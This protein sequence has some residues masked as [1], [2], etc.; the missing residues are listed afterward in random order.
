[1]AGMM[2]VFDD[3]VQLAAWQHEARD[4]HTGE[5]IGLTVNS[6][7]GTPGS[8][9]HITRTEEG[10]IPLAA[11]ADLKG[12]EGEQ[13]GEHTTMTPERFEALKAD[14]AAN[15]IRNPIFITVDPGMPPEISEGSNRRDAAAALGMTHVPALVR[16]FGHSE[17][18][19]TVTERAF[20]TTWYHGVPTGRQARQIA[21]SGLKSGLSTKRPYYT[22]A[23]HPD[24]AGMWAGKHG[25]VVEFR[26]PKS[27]QADYLTSPPGE[28]GALGPARISG[29]KRFIPA[30][31]VHKVTYMDPHHTTM[32]ADTI[33]GQIQLASWQTEPRDAT[34]RWSLE[35]IG[36]LAS[37]DYEGNT[38][39]RWARW[40]LRNPANKIPADQ[41]ARWNAL[42]ED[43][44]RRGVQEPVEVDSLE[45]PTELREGHHRYAAAL[46][47]G[48]KDI[49]VIAST[50][51]ATCPN[52]SC[53]I[54]LA[55]GWH[56][57]WRHELRG[58]HGEWVG[59]MAATGH[60]TTGKAG[61]IKKIDAAWGRSHGWASPSLHRASE[62]LKADDWKTAV[63]KLYEA[64]HM[65]DSQMKNPGT[66]SRAGASYRRLA[67]Q[68]EEEYTHK[69]ALSQV[70]T[71]ANT[72]PADQVAGWLG[73]GQEKWDRDARVFDW[74]SE[75]DVAGRM[76]WAGEFGMSN[77]TAEKLQELV[78]PAQQVITPDAEHAVSLHE[79]IHGVETPLDTPF[80][81]SGLGERDT[82]I[83]GTMDRLSLA[84]SSSDLRNAR[85]ALPRLN[86]YLLPGE[87][88]ITEPEMDGLVK[89]GYLTRITN[90]EGKP[91]WGLTSKW[92]ADRIGIDQ[93]DEKLHMQAY[94]RYP[95]SR[96]E[97]GFT[98]LG[99]NHHMPDWLESVGAAGKLTPSLSEEGAADV[100]ARFNT[101]AMYDNQD[102]IRQIYKDEGTKPGTKG[103]G[104]TYSAL[105]NAE[106]ALF[107]PDRD[108]VALVEALDQAH[109]LSPYP[110]ITKRIEAVMSKMNV[111]PGT[112]K[113]QTMGEYAEKLRDLP[114]NIMNNTAW[115]H[116]PW[117]TNAALRWV[118]TI[119]RA[120]GYDPSYPRG[121]GAKRA[122]ELADEIN[123]QGPA[124]KIPVMVG[125]FMRAMKADDVPAPPGFG[126]SLRQT[127]EGTLE[128]SWPT[129]YDQD[130]GAPY[131]RLMEELEWRKGGGTV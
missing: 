65:A 58:P 72:R 77:V 33:T 22:L 101:Q 51:L 130:A 108:P 91:A 20:T 42:A 34:G 6:Y 44:G 118:Q 55:G 110:D 61:F 119:A 66:K 67:D 17:E 19:G 121:P 109:S 4:P 115:G 62:A 90:Y 13:P 39:D 126:R 114:V 68:I 106:H 99:T 94:Q 48:Q 23:S 127:L 30:E 75:P 89:R 15:G 105:A 86:V 82:Q 107:S 47:H 45:H 124:G 56:D 93:D 28:L 5:W 26:I 95:V 81:R 80:K 125:Q 87:A 25:A 102:E 64:A 32:A 27:K 112:L 53:P 40:F 70:V 69:D 97:E 60:A 7:Q 74:A 111:P 129:S 103:S 31:W 43:V 41:L 76:G 9:R 85:F 92:Y 29:I 46:L 71:M 21:R 8:L 123:Q 117:E 57:A 38:V 84:G 37:G 24:E 116:Y 49:P 59:G 100:R 122:I 1:M 131:K 120:E 12:R 98:E 113:R 78:D 63:S 128:N 18:K 52:C 73:G 96:I 88:E 3:G 36:A 104:D 2:P 10:Q 11:I 16:Y 14:I 35:K 79:L 50:E 83:L 54:E